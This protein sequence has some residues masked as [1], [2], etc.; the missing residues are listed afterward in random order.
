MENI[1]DWI[2]DVP[3]SILR[4]QKHVTPAALVDR[5][6]KIM[7]GKKTDSSGERTTSGDSQ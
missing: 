7:G 6:V 4:V 2:E 3:G 5:I 1:N